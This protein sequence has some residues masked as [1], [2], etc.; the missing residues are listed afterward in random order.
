MADFT[1]HITINSPY[2]VRGII[3]EE[4]RKHW[5]L[6]LR[7]IALALKELTASMDMHRCNA[8]KML[9][10]K[11][12]LEEVLANPN[13]AKGD[14]I[15]AKYEL[16]ALEREMSDHPTPLEML[17]REYDVVLEEKARIES[18]YASEI[19]Q[20]SQDQ[21]AIEAEADE[22]K[23]IHALAVKMIASK[24]GIPEGAADLLVS[25]ADENRGRLIR[26]MMQLEADTMSSMQIAMGSFVPSFPEE[27]IK[28]IQQV[29]EA[30]AQQQQQQRQQQQY[31]MPQQPQ[32]FSANGRF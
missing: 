13:T 4:E 8:E 21:L 16:K 1:P 19:A 26:G 12:E 9:L 11:E 17:Q 10:K 3:Q 18:Q 24:T 30:I 22:A 20:A 27:K 6:G 5:Y 28:Q 23:R 29:E 31:A 7:Q 25:A 14:L 32:Q 2:Q 15:E